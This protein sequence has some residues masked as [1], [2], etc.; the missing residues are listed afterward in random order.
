MKQKRLKFVF[1]AIFIILVVSLGV[2]L[3]IKSDKEKSLTVSIAMAL[4]DGYTYPTIVAITSMMETKNSDTHYDYYIMHPGEFK[5]ENKEKLKSLE[6]KYPSC[7]IN[8][9]D[10][11][12]KY[13]NANDHGRIT[14]PA[15]YRLS[16]SELIPNLDKIIFSPEYG[17]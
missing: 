16:I 7:K 9:I 8:L 3:K 6:K 15:Y 4:D 5:D 11:Q 14:T 1:V 17:L 13:K 12:N 10:M 2:F